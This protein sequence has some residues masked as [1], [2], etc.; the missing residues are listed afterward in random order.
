MSEENLGDIVFNEDER[1]LFGGF[2]ESY[3][4]IFPSQAEL[5]TASAPDTGSAY[6]AN[7]QKEHA[8]R[9]AEAEI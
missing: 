3:Y 9:M 8:N 6:I 4:D 7:L 5:E 2:N 1:H